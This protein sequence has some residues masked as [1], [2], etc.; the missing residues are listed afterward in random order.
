MLS[1]TKVLLCFV[2]ILIRSRGI[3][4]AILHVFYFGLQQCSNHPSFQVFLLKISDIRG[5]RLQQGCASLAEYPNHLHIASRFNFGKIREQMIFLWKIILY[6]LQIVC[7]LF[8]S[9][10]AFEK[11]ATVFLNAE[12]I[13]TFS[14]FLRPAFCCSINTHE[15]INYT[16]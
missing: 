16:K 4:N 3:C 6:F 8:K 7:P 14:G 13:H 5:L 10:M 2:L 9:K 12:S 11:S 15:N 1:I